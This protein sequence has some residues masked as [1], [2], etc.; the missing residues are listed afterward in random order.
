[1]STS[2]LIL[3]FD[4][5]F[6]S[7]DGSSTEDLNHSKPFGGAEGIAAPILDLGKDPAKHD[8]VWV[9]VPVVGALWCFGGHNGGSSFGVV[10]LGIIAQPSSF[11][12]NLRLV[13]RYMCTTQ[14][15]TKKRPL[16][17]GL[18]FHKSKADNR[19]DVSLGCA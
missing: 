18:T 9:V 1:M 17:R 11:W 4:D 13:I 12:L 10:G 19:V 8:P 3:Q 15:S 16:I 7:R 2:D 6:V 14:V 5:P